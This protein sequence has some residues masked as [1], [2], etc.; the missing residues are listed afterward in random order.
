MPTLDQIR[1]GTTSR[2]T[3]MTCAVDGREHLVSDHAT[4][5]GLAIGQG[6]YR[7]VCGHL[8]IA[9]VRG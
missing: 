7:A 5:A 1:S 6:R 4:K 3:M 2:S 9:A 8:A